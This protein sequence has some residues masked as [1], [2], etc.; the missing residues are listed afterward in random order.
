MCTIF[1]AFEILMTIFMN[2]NKSFNEVD[3]LLKQLDDNIINKYKITN[4]TDREV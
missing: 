2:I 1:F 4:V 3:N